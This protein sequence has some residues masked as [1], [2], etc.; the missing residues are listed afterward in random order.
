MIAPARFD[1]K[2]LR[3]FDT[4]H[5]VLTITLPLDCHPYSQLQPRSIMPGSHSRRRRRG[6]DVYRPGPASGVEGGSFASRTEARTAGGGPDATLAMPPPLFVPSARGRAP[7]GST[8]TSF[9]FQQ[10]ERQS[11]TAAAV[12][13]REPCP[14]PSQSSSSGTAPWPP[15]H[16]PRAPRGF[17]TQ[18]SASALSN[19][20]NK[21]PG[22]KRSNWSGKPKRAAPAT[23]REL[24]LSGTT[25]GPESSLSDGRNGSEPDPAVLS[26]SSNE[27]DADSV[28]R[29]IPRTQFRAN[30]FTFTLPE[31][32]Q[33]SSYSTEKPSLDFFITLI[34][35]DT[36]LN[37]FKPD[38]TGEVRTAA[39]FRDAL[40]ACQDLQMAA[41]VHAS[42]NDWDIVESAA[43]KAQEH[44][45]SCIDTIDWHSSL[46]QMTEDALVEELH[47]LGSDTPWA[48]RFQVYLWDTSSQ[49][50]LESIP[51]DQRSHYE[52]RNAPRRASVSDSQ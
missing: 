48:D 30:R 38:Y 22:R 8:S 34:P 35:S 18:S 10:P 5:L 29:V 6:R 28:H 32:S 4:K 15:V 17:V 1:K 41:E 44:F 20:K 47:G 23:A 24:D 46:M 19:T 11:Q 50:I 31:K 42:M 52:V 9:T 33:R 14:V 26:S 13:D 49:I 51:E 21:R 43:K 25:D 40:G 45:A 37:L 36:T 2:S 39:H 12:E 16:L 27:A 3:A 7:I